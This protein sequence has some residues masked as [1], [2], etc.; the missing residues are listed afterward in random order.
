MALILTA[1]ARW[2]ERADPGSHRRVKGLRLVTAYGLAAMCGALQESGKG[3][4]GGN[5]LSSLAGGFA[6]WASVSEGQSSRGKSARDLLILCGAAGVGALSMLWLSPLLSGPGRP[7]SELTLAS[8]AFLVGYLKRF[9]ISG[10]GVGSQIYIGQL[11]AFGAGLMPPDAGTVVLASGIAA[12]SAMVPRFL[13]GP[14]E[15]PVSFQALPPAGP[16]RPSTS[17]AMG[18]QAATAALAIVLLNGVVALEESAWAVT[19]CTYV[20]ASSATGTMDRVRRRILGTVIG[21]PF[22]LVLLPA[23]AQR[24][25]LLWAAAALAM[26]VYAI[27]LPDR[28]DVACGAFAFTLMVTLAASGVHSDLL[29]T[30]RIWETI[31]GCAL[32]LA[33][34]RLV[35]PLGGVLSRE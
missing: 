33:A 34:S 9:G 10:A 4:S 13:S 35:F 6:L 18:V 20:I 14:A 29:L 30:A 25:I 2:L 15:H 27:A 31:I 3:A 19:A 16:R 5:L 7:G 8:G 24:P 22:G 32:G 23:A 26:I 11:L 28:Y 17:L 12:I 21:V 1:P